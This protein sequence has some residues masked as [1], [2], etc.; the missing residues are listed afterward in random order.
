[1]DWGRSCCTDG[2]RRPVAYASTALTSTEQWYEQ[3]EREALA[4]TGACE[5]FRLFILGLPFHVEMDHKPL[6]P[7]FSSK[8]IDGLTP[9]L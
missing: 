7:I 2:H 6:A 1:M 5:K 9:R 4:V 8:R 3:V